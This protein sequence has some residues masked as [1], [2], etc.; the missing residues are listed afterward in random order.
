MKTILVSVSN[1]ITHDQ[2]VA[3]VCDTLHSRGFTVKVIGRKLRTSSSIDFPYSTKRIRLL[4]NKGFCFYFE[5]NLR[6]FFILLFHKKDILIA[7]DLDTLVPNQLVSYL[8][9]KKLIF[10]SHELF[11]E[12]PELVNR[13]FTKSIWR[14]LEDLL[15]SRQKHG[16]TVSEGIARHYKNLHNSSFEVIKNYPK[17]TNNEIAQTNHQLRAIKKPIILY[18]GA[19]NIGRGLALMIDAM[20]YL[21]DFTFVIIGAGDLLDELQRKV[22]TL[23][24][25]KRILFLGKMKPV[26][27]KSITPLAAVGISL[28]E[29]LGL[30]YRFALP[31]KIF[32]Y[33]QAEVPVLVSDLPEMAETI[34]TFKVGEI[35]SSRNP[36]KLA[37][38]IKNLV[39]KDFSIHLRKAKQELIWE[40]QEEKLLRFF[41]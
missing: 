24:Y 1:D 31:N 2:R 14:F 22:A 13:K 30:N 10:D 29:D 28:E 17:K 36:Q 25:K 12:I 16:I 41:E 5:F 34:K 15:I 26:E 38:Q 21:P 40:H 32:D 8:Q 18:Q 39:Q 4:F 3:K 11:S 20:Q 7:N 19:V 6:L 35:A 23:N 27:L 9:R 33:I 37:A